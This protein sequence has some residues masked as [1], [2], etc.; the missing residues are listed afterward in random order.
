MTLV[1]VFAVLLVT[2]VF[3]ENVSSCSFRS[4]FS[5][6][7][8]QVIFV[9]H[10]SF[11]FFLVPPHPGT[12][13]L[14]V[15]FL[16]TSSY[17]VGHCYFSSWYSRSGNWICTKGFSLIVCTVMLQNYCEGKIVKLYIRERF[18]IEKIRQK[19]VN[20]KT[21]FKIWIWFGPFSLSLPRSMSNLD[22]KWVYVYV[23]VYIYI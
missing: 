18:F 17:Y 13:L 14:V 15:L 20:A 21:L 11:K 22:G 7:D 16:F 1:I 4:F 23:C 9:S 6:H 8:L 12:C 19:K 2:T 5:S 10:I 3:M